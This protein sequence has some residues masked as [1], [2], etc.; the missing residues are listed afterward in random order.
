MGFYLVVI[1]ILLNQSN[2]ANY[3][4]LEKFLRRNLDPIFK[5]QPFHGHPERLDTKLLLK[6]LR[7]TALAHSFLA[8]LERVHKLIALTCDGG[9]IIVYKHY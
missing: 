8:D 9:T 5:M 2:L 4:E 6:K 1:T 7:T 3:V